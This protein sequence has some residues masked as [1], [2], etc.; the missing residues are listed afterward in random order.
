MQSEVNGLK[1]YD[2]IATTQK[3]INTKE[4][5]DFGYSYYKTK[6]MVAS[7]ELKR[8]NKKNYENL[9]FVGEDT[10][11]YY[12][13]AY[14]PRGVVCLMSAAVFYGL[15]TYQ[16][17]AIDVAINREAD[18]AHSLPEWPIF[19]IY[20]FH[21]DRFEEGIEVITDGVNQF[22]IYDVEKT[23]VDIIYYRNKIGIEETKEVLTNYLRRKD[24]NINK[25]CRYADKLK[26]RDILNTYMEVLV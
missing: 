7:G 12:L 18:S 9:K 26:V 11:F 21:T 24:R 15:S 25:L 13:K 6:Q 8:L 23:V 17:I 10:E 5:Y 19:S 14:I 2:D 16:P 1:A 20:R 22:R 3:I 4:L